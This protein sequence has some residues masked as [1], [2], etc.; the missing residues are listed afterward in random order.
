MIFSIGGVDMSENKVA[1]I[2]KYF[3][4]LNVI[5]GV[6]LG[7]IGIEY[8]EV[9]AVVFIVANIISSVFIFAIGEIIQKLENIDNNTRKS[10][11]ES[12][13]L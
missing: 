2:I 1:R 9:Y 3:A 10:N 8:F 5:A 12:P 6:I 7:L 13:K 11:N 4:I